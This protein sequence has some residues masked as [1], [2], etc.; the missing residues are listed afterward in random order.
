MEDQDSQITRGRVRRRKTR[1]EI[2]QKDLEISVLDKDI[3]C[4]RKL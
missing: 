1:R 4:G 2:I 3:I